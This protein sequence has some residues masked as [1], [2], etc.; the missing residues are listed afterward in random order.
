MDISY[1][2]TIIRSVNFTYGKFI[3]TVFLLHDVNSFS[4]FCT[5]NMSYNLSLK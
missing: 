2:V 5:L 1:S 3:D 4:V